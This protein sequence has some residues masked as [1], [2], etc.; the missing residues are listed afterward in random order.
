MPLVPATLTAE[1]IKIM[2]KESPTHEGFPENTVEAASRWADAIN[3][4]AQ[5]V[6]PPSANAEAARSAFETAMLAVSADA[7]NFYTVIKAAFTAYA[8]QLALGMAPT[9]TGVPPPVPIV[10]E[11]TAA[12]GLAGGTGSAVAAAMTAIIDAWFRTGTAVNASSG[13]T[14]IWS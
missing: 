9:F 4:Y 14:T 7:G 13:A 11:P 5:S 6:V 1:L 10:L 8:A 2:D 12:I 3:A